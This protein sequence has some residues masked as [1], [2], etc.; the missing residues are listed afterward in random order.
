M[1][2]VGGLGMKIKVSLPMPLS[3]GSDHSKTILD[4][5]GVALASGNTEVDCD[6]SVLDTFIAAEV[7]V[8]GTAP[9]VASGLSLEIMKTAQ[10]A[11]E[12]AEDSGENQDDPV[13]AYWLIQRWTGNLCDRW[14]LMESDKLPAANKFGTTVAAI[15]HFFANNAALSQ[16]VCI[17]L[18]CC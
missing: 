6:L 13:R 12:A 11:A 16:C 2:M 17:W 18:D 8:A 14:N 5:N 4:H 10:E 7:V 3:L 9:S 1:T 15:C